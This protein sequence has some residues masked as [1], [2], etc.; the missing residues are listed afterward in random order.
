MYKFEFGITTVALVW[1][2]SPRT[3]AGLDPQ[4]FCRQ[5]LNWLRKAQKKFPTQ[6]YSNYANPIWFIQNFGNDVSFGNNQ[7][8]NGNKNLLL[9]FP[10]KMLP[11]KPQS[12]TRVSLSYF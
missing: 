6:K 8:L 3:P 9:R 1:S 10:H 12:D 11:G 7:T 4:N 2:L 5:T